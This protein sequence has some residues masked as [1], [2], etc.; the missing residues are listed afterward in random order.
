MHSGPDIAV[1][2]FLRLL[3][4]RPGAFNGFTQFVHTFHQKC[5]CCCLVQTSISLHL[6]VSW[7]RAN[8]HLEAWEQFLLRA[9]LRLLPDN[10][11]TK[12]SVAEFALSKTWYS[13][14]SFLLQ[15]RQSSALLWTSCLPDVTVL[16]PLASEESQAMRIIWNLNRCQGVSEVQSCLYPGW[17]WGK[18]SIAQ[19][20]PF[21]KLGPKATKT[22]K[23]LRL[24][25]ASQLFLPSLIRLWLCRH[26]HNVQWF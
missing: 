13:L 26:R 10:R 7:L 11:K 22:A 18:I 24:C 25:L 9:G 14:L 1:W 15:S 8:W 6:A 12:D 20:A 2:H 23:L 17:Q 16:R 3:F 4:L 19:L 21:D 5:W